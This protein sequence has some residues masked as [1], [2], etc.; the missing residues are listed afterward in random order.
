MK[1]QN[2]SQFHVLTKVECAIINGGIVEV[3][4]GGKADAPK[5]GGGTNGGTVGNKNCEF[6]LQNPPSPESPEYQ[7]YL[8]CL[9]GGKSEGALGIEIAPLI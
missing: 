9:N 4:G 7:F 5:S 1:K 2:E 3:G 6:Y 8:E